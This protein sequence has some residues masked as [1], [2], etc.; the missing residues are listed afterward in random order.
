MDQ[1]ETIEKNFQLQCEKMMVTSL[2]LI[3][4]NRV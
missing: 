4:V 3:Q 1:K 2:A